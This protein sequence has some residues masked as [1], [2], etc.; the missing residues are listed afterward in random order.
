[1]TPSRH[2]LKPSSSHLSG[3]LI[4]RQQ[5][6]DIVGRQA[7]RS[8]L[9]A[10]NDGSGKRQHQAAI[11]HMMAIS[12][13]RRCGGGGRADGPRDPGACVY[14]QTIG[15]WAGLVCCAWR[16]CPGWVSVA[17]R[18][19]NMTSDTDLSLARPHESRAT[20]RWCL[21]C[22]TS[23]RAPCAARSLALYTPP[24]SPTRTPYQAPVLFASLLRHR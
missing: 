21:S 18:W 7:R 4:T 20:R 10:A 13:R 2:L 14:S 6:F 12:D 17:D 19:V 5:N 3:S 16:G 1:M 15:R 8:Q 22:A 24:V 11:N 23:S 9:M